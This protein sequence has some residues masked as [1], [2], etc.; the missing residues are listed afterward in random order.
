MTKRWYLILFIVTI[1]FILFVASFNIYE[2]NRI[3]NE[4]KS[5]VQNQDMLLLLN[6]III[7]L[8]ILLIFG[9]FFSKESKKSTSSSF[10]SKIS[11]SNSS[12]MII[13]PFGCQDT[14]D[15]ISKI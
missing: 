12:Q 8:A 2:Q 15:I 11:S 5:C 13:N 10:V 3:K 6:G 9:Y 14:I 1:L 7:F 4:C